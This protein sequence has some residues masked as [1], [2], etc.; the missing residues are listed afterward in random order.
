MDEFPDKSGRCTDGRWQK[1]HTG[2][3]HGR[4][5]NTRSQLAA[6]LDAAAETDAPAVYEA[7]RDAAI[8][9]DVAAQSLLMGRWWPLVKR[10]H[11]DL[12][13]LPSVE[14]AADIGRACAHIVARVANGEMTLEEAL[15]LSELLERLQKSL[16]AVD[17]EARLVAL[18]EASRGGGDDRPD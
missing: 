6:T 8:K 3:P 17:F 15:G 16:L 11:V 5:R 14:T 9:G 1:G 7:I 2:N 10:T 4:P 12:S 18:E 13:D